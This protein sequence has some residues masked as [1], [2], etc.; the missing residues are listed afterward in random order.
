M[1]TGLETMK[2]DNYT[3]TTG[4]NNKRKGFPFIPLPDKCFNARSKSL[5][6]AYQKLL[7]LLDWSLDISI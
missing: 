4:F 6:R 3:A 7:A 2:K 5:R 1:I